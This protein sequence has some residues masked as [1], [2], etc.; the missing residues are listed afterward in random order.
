MASVPLLSDRISVTGLRQPGDMTHLLYGL[1]I[2]F[3]QRRDDGV[4][5]PSA[6]ARGENG[7]PGRESHTM[8]NSAHPPTT[9]EALVYLPH[10]IHSPDLHFLRSANPP[11]RYLALLQG[12]H[13]VNF[14]LPFGGW[15]LDSNL[16]AHD[17]LA[18]HN[19]L[20]LEKGFTSW[21]LRREAL[22]F[23]D[24]LEH[25]LEK[26]EVEGAPI[27]TDWAELGSGESRLLLP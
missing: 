21:F 25:T 7:R 12:L 1:L 26:G 8:P 13:L 14:G 4:D 11:L 10:G 18:T 22:T 17:A 9:R 19:E 15:N 5:N 20:K 2:T 3:D 23:E 24:A 16:G 27:G 6:H